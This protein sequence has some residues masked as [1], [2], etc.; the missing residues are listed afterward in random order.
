MWLKEPGRGKGRRRGGV[1]EQVRP[2]RLLE[3]TRM[4]LEDTAL[5][6][7]PHLQRIRVN[8]DAQSPIGMDLG[9]QLI[10]VPE[11]FTVTHFDGQV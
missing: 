10:A 3:P 1:A 7:L 11:I 9:D 4:L 5:D 6:V 2:A 8:I